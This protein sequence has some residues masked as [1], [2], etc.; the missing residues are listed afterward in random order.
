MYL[1]IVGLGGIGRNLVDIA[2][3]DKNDV[4][5]I[6]ADEKRCKEIA[7]KYDVLTIVGDATQKSTLE[8]ANAQRAN[9]LIATTSDDANN[10]LM[11]LTAKELGTKNIVA[12]VNQ[13]EH[14]EMFKK[15]DI[16]MIEKPD[17]TVARHLYLQ[18]KRP[19][20]K[21]FISVGGGKAEIFE[22]IVSKDSRAVG[23]EL[24][25]LNIRGGIV[26]AVERNGDMI[27]PKGDTVFKAGDLVTVF[28]MSKDV[29]L[30]SALFAL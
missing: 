16:S 11:A 21:D 2:T 22:V 9:A 28:A 26:V 18:A 30:I 8:E 14:V 20:V 7:S 3:K 17:M 13:E 19:K 29:E 23:K 24:S 15:A 10:L 27:L 6:D 1:I 25:Q 5:V 12:V 4:V